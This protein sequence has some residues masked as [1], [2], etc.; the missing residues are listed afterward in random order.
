MIS[1]QHYYGNTT[2]GNHGSGYH[3]NENIKVFKKHRVRD[4]FYSILLSMV[5]TESCLSEN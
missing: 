1:I 2:D 3:P 5:Q 4:H